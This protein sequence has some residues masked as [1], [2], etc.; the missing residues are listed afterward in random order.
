[1]RIVFHCEFK[2]PVERRLFCLT[3]ES[4]LPARPIAL[5]RVFHVPVGN[6]LATVGTSHEVRDVD[7]RLKQRVF[8]L[9]QFL[10]HAIGR[11]VRWIS[12]KLVIAIDRLCRLH[13]RRIHSNAKKRDERALTCPIS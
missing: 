4:S 7:E 5:L 1:M 10:V 3:N 6:G 8:G 12:R 13:H 9:V 11:R 2:Q